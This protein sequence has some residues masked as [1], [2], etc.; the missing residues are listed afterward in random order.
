MDKQYRSTIPGFGKKR[1][2]SNAC[3]RRRRSCSKT[4]AMAPK[5]TR[6]T[7]GYR[8]RRKRS[9][10]KTRGNGEPDE[11]R[12][13]GSGASKLKLEEERSQRAHRWKTS[14]KTPHTTEAEQI[15]FGD[16]KYLEASRKIT[17]LNVKSPR[18]ISFAGETLVSRER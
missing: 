13:N 16:L 7:A 6:A 17:R 18:A 14:P 1:S 5:V 15:R 11:R 3:Q 4:K 9:K 10:R 2:G 12:N 8:R